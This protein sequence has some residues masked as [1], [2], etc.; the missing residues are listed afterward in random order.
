[1]A[2]H[3]LRGIAGASADERTN[4]L[5]VRGTEGAIKELKGLC[6]RLDVAVGD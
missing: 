3:L 5:I 4:S 2:P 1:M 6:E